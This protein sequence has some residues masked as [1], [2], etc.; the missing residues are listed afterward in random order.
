VSEVR[1]RRRSIGCFDLCMGFTHHWTER[2][3]NDDPLGVPMDVL[4][5][6]KKP[7]PSTTGAV[8]YVFFLLLVQNMVGGDKACLLNRVE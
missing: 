8:D 3:R 1:G 7:F 5:Q 2:R 4:Y 6:Q